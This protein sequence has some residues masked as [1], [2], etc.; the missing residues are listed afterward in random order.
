MARIPGADESG[1]EQPEF[2]L[3]VFEMQ[4]SAYGR[5][6]ENTLLLA[7]RPAILKAARG[8][9][10]GLAQSGTLDPVLV[11]LVNVRVAGLIGCPF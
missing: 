5:V 7:R 10:G 11:Q 6:L 4:R 9:W 3:R 8:M 2:T 1:S